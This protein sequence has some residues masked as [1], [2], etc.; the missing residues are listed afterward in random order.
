MI[1]KQLIKQNLI[2]SIKKTSV[3]LPENTLSSLK[4]AYESEPTGNGKIVL[5]NILK[6]L[7]IARKENLPMCQDTGMLWFLVQIGEKV[8]LDFSIPELLNEI[9]VEVFKTAY[10]RASVVSDPLLRN[11]TSNNSPPV[12]QFEFIKENKLK[13]WFML[14]GFGSENAGY[15]W[16]LRPTSTVEDIAKQVVSRVLEVGGGACPP[17][18]L[19]LGIGG[20]LDYA[21]LLSKKALFI[22]DKQKP[23]HFIQLEDLITSEINASGLGPGGVGGKTAVL[24]TSVLFYPTHIAGLPVVLSVSCWANRKGMLEFLP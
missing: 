17:V 3:S 11:N 23:K 12:V 6:N 19:G 5:K 9:S 13:I 8:K 21:A 22:H 15:S 14:K 10:L 7:E 4:R 24:D 2:S 20:T 16:L 18:S 1:S